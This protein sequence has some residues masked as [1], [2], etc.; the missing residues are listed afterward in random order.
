MS[1]KRYF[2]N[3]PS[4]P[5]GNLT[6]GQRQW[7]LSSLA[8]QPY[9]K[10]FHS[11]TKNDL[12]SLIST[13]NLGFSKRRRLSI[14]FVASSC[15][16]KSFARINLDCTPRDCSF[17]RRDFPKQHIQK[18]FDKRRFDLEV[19]KNNIVYLE[20]SRV[21]RQAHSSLHVGISGVLNAHKG[22]YFFNANCAESNTK[23]I[24]PI[25]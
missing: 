25:S 23:N 2:A 5:D 16:D 22:H 11:G 20:L 21:K 14:F 4:P 8:N 12:V 18:L 15:C 1:W 9:F 24:P 13:E 10:L 6:Q 7:H 19:E 17:L 3:E